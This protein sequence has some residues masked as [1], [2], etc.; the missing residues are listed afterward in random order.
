M[1]KKAK[2]ISPD[3][4][5]SMANWSEYCK[6]HGFDVSTEWITKIRNGSL[7]N[8][9]VQSLNGF[10]KILGV[11]V[12]HLVDDGSKIPVYGYVN[13]EKGR[14]K[15]EW[16]SES[17]PI[18]PPIY[19]IEGNSLLN[20]SIVYGLEMANEDDPQT[21]IAI[22]DPSYPF[23]SDL[24]CI[25][26]LKDGRV[27]FR[28]VKKEEGGYL[29]TSDDPSVKPEYVANDKVFSVHVVRQLTTKS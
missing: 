20:P 10:A 9:T 23:Q 14:A 26:R 2:Q 17:T 15:V 4:R 1:D 24:R 6:K 18:N 27:I 22:A 13:A 3:N 16:G 19:R 29:L 7:V 25:V 21:W 11:S 8:P 5:M 12:A 28:T